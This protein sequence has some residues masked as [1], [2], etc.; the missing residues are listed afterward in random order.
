MALRRIV[1]GV[2]GTEHSQRALT[3]AL[4]EAVLRKTP[5]MVLY[6]CDI[7]SRGEDSYVPPEEMEE[8][9]A[10]GRALLT[11]ALEQVSA[12]LREGVAVEEHITLAAPA[13]ALIAASYDA[14]LLVV[15]SRGRSDVKELLLGS[16][17]S[18][19]VHHARCPIVVIPT[20]SRS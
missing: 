1:V 13:A 11:R 19:C 17:S 2:D 8:A 15:A 4:A 5:C 16:V 12:E 14:V 10:A 20:S 18:A 3:W 9:M 6:A 7:E